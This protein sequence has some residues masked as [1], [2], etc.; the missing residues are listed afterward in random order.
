MCK[1]VYDIGKVSVKRRFRKDNGRSDFLQD[2]HRNLLKKY[3]KM[4]KMLD[5]G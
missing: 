5:K 3:K 4:H 1:Q 2:E